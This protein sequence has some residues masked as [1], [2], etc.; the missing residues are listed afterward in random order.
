MPRWPFSALYRFYLHRILPLLAGAVTGN[1]AGYEY[2]GESIESF[3]SGDAMCR[4]INQTGFIGPQT[5]PLAAGIVAIYTAEK[6]SI[7]SAP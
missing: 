7:P 5:L 6:S 3:P 1:R 4:L 2:L